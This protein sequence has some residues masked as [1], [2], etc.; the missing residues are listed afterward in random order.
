MNYEVDADGGEEEVG[1]DHHCPWEGEDGGACFSLVIDYWKKV[2]IEEACM[3][4]EACDL[5][6][7]WWW[8]VTGRKEETE[9]GCFFSS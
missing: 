5:H 7:R 4:W 2:E 9:V 6:Q 1:W 8:R 3:R